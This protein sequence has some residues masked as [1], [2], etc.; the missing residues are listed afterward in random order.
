MSKETLHTLRLTIPGILFLIILVTLLE[1][2]KGILDIKISAESLLYIG[3]VFVFGVLFYVFSPR[4]YIMKN[5]LNKITENIKDKLLS[6]FIDDPD[7]KNSIIKLRAGD[8]LINVFYHIIDKD[9]SL[10]ERTKEVYFNGLIWSSLADLTIISPI[11]MIIYIVEYL[12]TKNLNFL[13]YAM[14]A[15][16]LC[17]LSILLIPLVVKRHFRLSNNQ[18]TYMSDINKKELREQLIAIL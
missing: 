16:G 3:V 17:I 14:V 8:K 13:I 15:L 12:Y 9:N 7:I 2:D 10:V 5:S 1:G 4:M 11:G 6:P 18:L